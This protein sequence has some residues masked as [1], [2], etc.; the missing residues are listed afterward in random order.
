MSGYGDYYEFRGL[1]IH[2]SHKET[3]RQQEALEKLK[4]PLGTEECTSMIKWALE[5]ISGNGGMETQVFAVNMKARKGLSRCSHEL[6]FTRG[7]VAAQKPEDPIK[8]TVVVSDRK[9]GGAYPI[10]M[11]EPST[12]SGSGGFLEAAPSLPAVPEV[13]L[14]FRDMFTE[15]SIGDQKGPL[16][17]SGHVELV[18][19][20]SKECRSSLNLSPRS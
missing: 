19:A 4:K 7:D 13:D 5:S 1:E 18:P 6:K 2:G 12:T 17:A 10:E 15:M 3:S 16:Q 20:S 8:L 14:S 11:G 9:R